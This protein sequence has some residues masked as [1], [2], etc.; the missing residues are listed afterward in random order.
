M[1]LCGGGAKDLDCRKGSE[2]GRSGVGDANFWCFVLVLALAKV[3]QQLFPHDR[4][5]ALS[6]GRHVDS[7]AFRGEWS[8]RLTIA[9]NFVVR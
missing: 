1:H 2:A 5:S 6:I 8:T 3:N 4:N 9:V 7:Q